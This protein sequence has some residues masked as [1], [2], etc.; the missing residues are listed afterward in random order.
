MKIKQFILL[1]I[2]FLPVCPFK[3]AFAA[4][5]TITQSEGHSCMGEDKSRKQTRDAALTDA[6]NRALEYVVSYA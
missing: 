4:Q 3:P 5:S 1:V 6:K 2:I